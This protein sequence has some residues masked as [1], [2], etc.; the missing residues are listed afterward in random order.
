MSLP[1]PP[2]VAF[3]LGWRPPLRRRRC[4]TL[5]L[6]VVYCAVASAPSASLLSTLEDVDLADDPRLLV[7]VDGPVGRLGG[8]Q[9]DQHIEEDVVVVGRDPAP[10]DRVDVDPDVPILVD[11]PQTEDAGVVR[12]AGLDD[13]VDGPHGGVDPALTVGDAEKP[14]LPPAGA[15][16]VLEDP[17]ALPVVVAD[18]TDAVTAG[19]TAGDVPVDTAPVGKEV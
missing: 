8:A 4:P 1:M 16:A 6:P 11:R 17:E 13:A 3:G 5:I 9:L 15:P 2:G 7:E 18:A 12:P 14:A 10:A 19:H